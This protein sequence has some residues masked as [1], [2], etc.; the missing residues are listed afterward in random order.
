MGGLISGKQQ[1]VHIPALKNRKDLN[2]FAFFDGGIRLNLL[3]IF[4]RKF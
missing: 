3:V 4:Q 2:F 1:E